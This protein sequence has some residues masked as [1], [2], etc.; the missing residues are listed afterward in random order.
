[1]SQLSEQSEMPLPTE[2]PTL[3]AGVT[4]KASSENVI[5]KD[6]AAPNSRLQMIL[7]FEGRDPLQNTV[8]FVDANYD[9]V[10]MPAT[11]YV[12]YFVGGSSGIDTNSPLGRGHDNSRFILQIEKINGIETVTAFHSYVSVGENIDLTMA[13]DLHRSAEFVVEMPYLRGA[14]KLPWF[15]IKA[16]PIAKTSNSPEVPMRLISSLVKLAQIDKNLVFEGIGEV[17]SLDAGYARFTLDSSRLTLNG[18]MPSP[19]A[20]GQMPTPK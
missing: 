10:T 1:M 16:W 14:Y 4:T 2:Q 12:T 7:R 13:S 18:D 3:P 15:H 17:T 20:I 6:V 8:S 11:Q 9:V 5:V 19:Q